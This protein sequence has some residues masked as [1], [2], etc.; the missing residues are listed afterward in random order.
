MVPKQPTCSPGVPI[1]LQPPAGH[2]RGE[3]SLLFLYQFVRDGYFYTA[4]HFT[5]TLYVYYLTS[6]WDVEAKMVELQTTKPKV[7]VQILAFVSEKRLDK[8]D[9]GRQC[10]NIFKCDHHGYFLRR[11]QKNVHP[12]LWQ[13]PQIFYDGKLGHIQLCSRQQS[14]TRTISLNK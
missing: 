12:C 14:I 3:C 10:F 5:F 6:Q 2:N 7:W 4:G 9:E 11:P 13:Q 1:L 8:I